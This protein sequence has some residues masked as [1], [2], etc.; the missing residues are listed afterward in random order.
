MKELNDEVK[1]TL[2]LMQTDIHE[3]ALIE[4]QQHLQKLLDIKRR[5]LQKTLPVGYWIDDTSTNEP[6]DIGMTDLKKA[7]GC[8]SHPST[9]E[10]STSIE[11]PS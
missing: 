8:Y 9:T 5:N 6:N 10:E 4:L 7:F 1:L 2:N 11:T 3:G